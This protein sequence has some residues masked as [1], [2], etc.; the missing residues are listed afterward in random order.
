[1]ESNSASFSRREFV[2]RF[3]PPEVGEFLFNELL[4]HG[5]VMPVEPS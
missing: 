3:P 5:I 1:L 2:E 4:E